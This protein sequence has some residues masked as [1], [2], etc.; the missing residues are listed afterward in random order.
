V[1]QPEPIKETRKREKR[2]RAP[3]NLYQRNGIWWIRYNVGG[4]KIRRSLGTPSL[5]EA[6]RLRD[7]I[8]AKRSVAAKFGIEEP[9]PRKEH[10]FA[11]VVEAWLQSRR[12]GELRPDT[13]RDGEAMVER[14][15]LPTLGHRLISEITVED[16]ERLI[17][18]LRTTRSKRTGKPLSRAYIA[19]VTK[20][21]GTIFRFAVKRRLH[22]GANP[23][24]QLER[25]PTPGPGRD[26]YLT[27]DEA[28]RLLEKLR[29]ETYYKVGLAL[30]TGLRWGEIHGLAWAD[31]ELGEN[32]RITIRRSWQDEPKTK[33]SAATIPISADAA[34]FLRRWKAE[35][36]EAVY[37]FPDSKGNIRKRTNRDEERRL[38]KV[39]RNL[40]I[41]VRVSPH[42]FRHT[43]A[44]W[45]CART[46]DPRKIQRLMRHASIQTTMGYV[47]GSA[48]LA[49]VIDKLPALSQARLTAV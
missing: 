20:S 32:P 43:F 30:A 39:G 33:H 11:E 8:L 47:H 6:K 34:A 18:H 4:R 48:D 27:E 24:D 25:R 21:L 7:Q 13:I 28:R 29:G 22:H 41:D 12:A 19:T 36:G 2:E 42:V 26:A 45:A 5:R 1:S 35:Q 14:W 9:I 17:S 49:D 15:L 40:Q 23:Y 31:V 3:D 10:T 16:V 37:V 44:T 46:Q 38:V